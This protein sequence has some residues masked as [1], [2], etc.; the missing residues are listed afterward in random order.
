MTHYRAIQH[1]AVPPEVFRGFGF[2]GAEDLRNMFQF[3]CDFE[4]Y[5]CGARDI[6]FTPSLNPELL[7]FDAWLAA[8]KELI[9]L[10]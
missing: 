10:K 2:P 1:N 5:Y 7:S 3:K 9:P 4:D 6:D 8:N